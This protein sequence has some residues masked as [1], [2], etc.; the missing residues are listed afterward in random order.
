[1][2]EHES[3]YSLSEGLGAV[4]G[5]GY[6]IQPRRN[7]VQEYC[8]HQFMAANEEVLQSPTCS[9][10]TYSDEWKDHCCGIPCTVHFPSPPRPPPAQRVDCWQQIAGFS[11]WWNHP[12]A[13]RRVSLSLSLFLPFLRGKG[14][15]CFWL[16][17]AS[18]SVGTA[19]IW[20]GNASFSLGKE[21][22]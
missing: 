11:Q 5:C 7:E 14:T 3:K 16:A 13:A 17:T 6:F 19:R 21:C 20:L 22:F 2:A 12:L 9:K 15:A 8:W 1:M 18:F 10:S 4:L